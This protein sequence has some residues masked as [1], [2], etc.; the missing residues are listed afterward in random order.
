[1]LMISDPTQKATPYFQPCSK[2][3]VLSALPNYLAKLGR[4]SNQQLLLCSAGGF[5]CIPLDHRA[6]GGRVV[7]VVDWNW[8]NAIGVGTAMHQEFNMNRY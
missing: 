3:K 5:F 4:D 7:I 2:R 8:Y 1:M 6:D